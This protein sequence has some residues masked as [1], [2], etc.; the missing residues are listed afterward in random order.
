MALLDP[1]T[2]LVLFMVLFA[3]IFIV[4]DITYL[5][6]ISL[7]AFL[8]TVSSQSW[9]R[10]LRLLAKFSPLIVVA[11]VIWS[12]FHRMSLFHVSYMGSDFAIG[13]FA[14]T[15]LF[16]LISVSISFILCVKPEDLVKGLEYFRIPYSIV[17]PLALSLRFVDTLSDEYISIKEALMVKGLELEKGSLLKRIKNYSYLL[18][19]FLIRG[20]EVADNI[21]LA[22]ELKAFSLRKQR[23]CCK[24]KKLSLLDIMMIFVSIITLL[25][26]I[27]HYVFGLI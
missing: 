15:R 21:V 25:I 27:S 17:F 5:L 19:P 2:K 9:K 24:G 22:M 1:R 20:I 7:A 4:K 10:F 11:F 16:A 14:A 12:L 6:L 13:V 8:I 23:R 26:A 3:L 18:I